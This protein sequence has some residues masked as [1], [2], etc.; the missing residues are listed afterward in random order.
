M[1][2]LVD[3]R[4]LID[5]LTKKEQRGNVLSGEDFNTFLKVAQA[6]HFDVEKRKAEGTSD[7][8]D[9][10]RA[11]IVTKTDTTSSGLVAIPTS[12]VYAKLLSAQRLNGSNFVRCDILSQL[13]L[14]ERLDNSLTVGTDALPL[15]SIEASNFR[16]YPAAYSNVK[17]VYYK[18]P[19]EPTLDWYYDANGS[20]VYLA[21]AETHTLGTGEYAYDGIVTTPTEITSRTVEL[22]WADNNDRIAIAYRILTKLG[23]TIPNNLAVELGASEVMKSDQKQ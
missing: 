16:F 13:E 23:V 3:I 21:A 2:T 22:E 8:I 20:I 10:L 18:Q 7:I 11:F 6:E 12:P 17:I 4:L 5:R 1:I 9:S 14:E 19:T 15:V